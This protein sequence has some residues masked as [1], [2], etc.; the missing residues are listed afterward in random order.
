[1][2]GM[3]GAGEHDVKFTK[4]QQKVKKQSYLRIREREGDRDRETERQKQRDRETER[5]TKRERLA[6]F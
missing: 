3:S 6:Y 5:Q 1:M 2:R 4:N